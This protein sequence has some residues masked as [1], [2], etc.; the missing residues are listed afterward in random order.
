M[1][2]Q[3]KRIVFLP[4]GVAENA[5]RDCDDTAHHEEEANEKEQELNNSFQRVRRSQIDRPRKIHHRPADE[6]DGVESQEF[7]GECVLERAR[8]AFFGHRAE[9]TAA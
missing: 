8:D 1:A 9:F 5:M 3:L 6:D 2:K 4:N 7:S